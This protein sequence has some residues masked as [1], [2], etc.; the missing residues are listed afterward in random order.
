MKI[1]LDYLKKLLEAMEAAPAPTFEST[2]YRRPVWIM[3]MISLSSIW[4]FSTIRALFKE[5]I[6]SRGLGSFEVSTD[7]RR[8]R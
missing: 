6:E 2:S 4:A 3:T 8:G 5:M 1:D 7:T